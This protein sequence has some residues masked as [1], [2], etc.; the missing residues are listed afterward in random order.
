[1]LQINLNNAIK[2]LKKIKAKK[3]LLQIPEGLKTKTESIITELEKN[4]FNV[5]VSMDPCFGACDVKPKESEMMNCDAVLHIG[6]TKFI[7]KNDKKI[8]YAPLTQEL[9]NFEEIK[10]KITRYLLDNNFSLIGIV[11]TAQYLHYLPEIK[12]HLEKN[13][14]KVKITNGKRVENGQVLGC[15]YSSANGKAKTILYFGDGLFHPLGIH[16]GTKKEVIIFDPILGT[17]KTLDEEKNNFLRKRFL[18]IEKAKEGKSFAILVSTKIGQNRISTAEKIKKELAHAGKKVFICSMDFI[19]EEKLLGLDVDV[20]VNTACPR[21]SID[22]FASYKKPLI[23]YN[24]VKYVLGQN[25][26]DYKT[27]IIY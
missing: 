3:V 27:E 8:I 21:L 4:D 17:I 10:N 5:I 9:T 2:D 23:N 18:L 14:I 15:N 16:F 20:L 24:E 12:K 1:M 13:K 19:S 22:D 11:T 6:H 25:Y 7:E 26:E